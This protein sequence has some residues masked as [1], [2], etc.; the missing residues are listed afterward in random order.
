MNNNEWSELA[1]K[2]ATYFKRKSVYQKAF[3][4]MRKNWQKYGKAS[5]KIKLSGLS[6][7][8][9]Q[10]IGGFLGKD[11]SEKT[12]QFRMIDFEKALSE[13]CFVGLPL[14]MLLTAYF[15]E[16]LIQNKVAVAQKQESQRIFMECLCEMIKARYGEDSAATCWVF[17][18]VKQTKFG[19]RLLVDEYKTKGKA[20]T[21]S[22]VLCVCN[23]LNYLKQHEKEPVRLAL[24][25][26]EVTLNPHAFDRQM[27]AGKL[28]LQALGYIYQN[29]NVKSAEEILMLYYQA[30]IKPDDISSF[31]TAYGIRL[32]TKEGEHMAYPAFI[33]KNESY[34]ITMSNLNQI[35][36]V[37]CER[38][39]VFLIENQMVFSHICEE[40]KDQ[41]IALL[42]T[43]GQM[44]TASL[45]MI[46]LLC[47]AGHQLYYNGDIDPEGLNIADRVLRRNKQC[48]PWRL[49]VENYEQCISQE[50]INEERLKKLD[51]V[52]DSRLLEVS[53]ALKEKKRAGYQE[54][55]LEQLLMDIRCS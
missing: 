48:V 38:S 26:A 25:G 17:E 39:V 30:G 8:E 53:A 14:E 13:T 27:P 43:S 18:M 41:N 16:V 24:L 33:K 1:K 32:F 47:A 28:L 9:Q 2:G 4:Q 12:V 19:H 45:I 31:T 50:K 37:Q 3:I 36:R 29:T 49:S 20:A 7:A 55:L 42:C 52:K 5:G 22:L 34:V 54:R 11:F 6:L 51:S 40:M 10:E 23:A 35:L 21:E 46:D 15:G 44:K